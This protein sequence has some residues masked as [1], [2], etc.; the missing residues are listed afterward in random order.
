[1]CYSVISHV[2]HLSETVIYW[3]NFH[4]MPSMW[5]C[6][7][8]D[9]QF[10][11]IAAFPLFSW[12]PSLPQRWETASALSCPD[13]GFT[14]PRFANVGCCY[15]DL[16]INKWFSPSCYLDLSKLIPVFL[17]LL[18]GSVKLVCIFCPLP[19]KAKL[20]FDQSFKVLNESKYSMPWAS[21]AFG[22]ALIRKM[23]EEFYPTT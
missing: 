9:T 19:E 1:M 15:M 6:G 14:L 20:N 11:R 10:P 17:T 12:T 18:H 16:S 22:N 21:C 8:A 13:A 23:L 2:A 7:R 5:G 4:I 3:I